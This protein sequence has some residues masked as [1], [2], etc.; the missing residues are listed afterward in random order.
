MT[1]PSWPTE[2]AEELRRRAAEGQSP[3][4]IAAALGLTTNQ[5]LGKAY[6][7][8]VNFKTR[9][10]AVNREMLERWRNQGEGVDKIAKRYGCNPSTVRNWLIRLGLSTR[11]PLIGP[12]D[13]SSGSMETTVSTGGSAA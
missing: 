10:Y 6:R 8:K 1:F 13:V 12:R 4:E 3:S 7:M 5:V 9:R 2:H 11:V